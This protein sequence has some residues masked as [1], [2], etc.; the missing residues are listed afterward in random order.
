[1]TNQ[2]QRPDPKDQPSGPLRWP[3]K[4]EQ[5]RLFMNSMSY[6]VD[7]STRQVIRDA[8]ERNKPAWVRYRAAWGATLR[9]RFRAVNATPA[10][11]F[12]Y[13]LLTVL[14]YCAL[15]SLGK[16]F[17]PNSELWILTYVT[18]GWL[19]SVFAAFYLPDDKIYLDRLNLIIPDRNLLIMTP[20]VLWSKL[21]EVSLVDR[22]KSGKR[23]QFAI[24]LTQVSKEESHIFL[25]LLD[26]DSLPALVGYIQQ[27]A[28]HARGLAQ[29]SEIEK[30]YDYQT[31]SLERVSYTQLWESSCTAQF[32]L[33]SF[34][35]LAPMARVQERYTVIEQIAAGGFSA[36]YLI[37]DDDGQQFVLKESVLPTN[38]DE[39]SKA[40]ATQQFQREATILAKLNHAQIATV[41][42]YFVES[43]RN[44]LRLEYIAGANMRQYVKENH[45]QSEAV[46]QNW[47]EQ[48]AAIL[49]YL[50]DLTP[51]VVHR[52]LSPDNVVVRPD[53]K[54]VLI[55]FGAANEFIGAATGTLVGKHAYMAPEQIRGNAEPISDIYSLGACAYFALSG[56]DPEPIRRASPKR[57]GL[58]VSDWFDDFIQNSTHLE[59]D[60][61]LASASACLEY[62]RKMK[63]QPTDGPEKQTAM[64]SQN[65]L[66]RLSLMDD[67]SAQEG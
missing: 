2:T 59:K 41:Y 17:F 3:A 55:D 24:K 16:C 49:I 56:R 8:E 19:L 18:G 64:S 30:F 33:T 23:S 9:K 22:A 13:L 28:P 25:E 14:A 32:G 51:P 52:D 57:D 10:Q 1:M 53:G 60:E 45:G 39:A 54:L 35:P 31:G 37:A 38:L 26:R 67:E 62:L 50:H 48:L 20:K 29:L 44:Y 42:D 61:R 46:T 27:F 43:G 4:R 21:E 65:S 6:S 12:I 40:K 7:A 58:K 47:T 63:A 5:I 36:I 34:T 66:K 11:R 15:G